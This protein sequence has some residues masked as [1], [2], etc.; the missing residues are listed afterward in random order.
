MYF[1]L[2]PICSHGEGGVYDLYCSQPLDGDRNVLASLFR[3]CVAHLVRWDLLNKN[4]CFRYLPS[5]EGRSCSQFLVTCHK[6]EKCFIIWIQSGKHISKFI[7]YYICFVPFLLLWIERE[8]VYPS[9]CRSHSTGLPPVD[10]QA[11]SVLPSR[12]TSCCGSETEYHPL[13]SALQFPRTTDCHLHLPRILVAHTQVEWLKLRQK[14][15]S[16]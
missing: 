6:T 5:S 16:H 3:T 2:R 14:H 4:L 1:G 8:R 12:A 15:T 10:S 13:W 11:G 9:P 7:M